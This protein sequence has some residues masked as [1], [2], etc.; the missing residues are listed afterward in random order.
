MRKILFGIFLIIL[1]TAA[2]LFVLYIPSKI[3]APSF[4][5]KTEEQIIQEW[6]NTKPIIITESG[7]QKR[8][9]AAEWIEALRQY[10]LKGENNEDLGYAT[11]EDLVTKIKSRAK[12]T[13]SKTPIASVVPT[14]TPTPVPIPTP[15]P[16]PAPTPTPTPTPT[17]VPPTPSPTPTPT[18]TP[19][20]MP[21][22]TPIPTPSPTPTP[23]PTPPAP[24]PPAPVCGNGIKETGEECDDGNTA[25][26]DGCS[27]GCWREY[28]G[29]QSIQ[30][31]LGEQCEPPNTATC[32]S[33]CKIIK[34]YPPTCFDN[35][36]NGDESDLDC[37]GSCQKCPPPGQ[38]TYLS[39]WDNNDCMTGNCQGVNLP[40]QDLNTGT[41]YTTPAQ[42][43]P[44]A[45]QMWIIPYQGR[46][47]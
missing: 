21:T 18:P 22:P 12:P 31:G 8:A 41:W 42:I 30:Y 29:D 33:N 14:P 10:W 40:A 7:Q 47:I 6:A 36:W 17:P 39:C 20:P 28:C 24:T 34:T 15:S 46:C 19:T 1:F 2:I 11:K 45:G 38:P 43:R 13:T 3:A 37:G 27:G 26:G 44:L 25:A 4:E 35:K 32:D 5:G 23:T 16:T 9:V